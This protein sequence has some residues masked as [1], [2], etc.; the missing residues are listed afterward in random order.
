MGGHTKSFHQ[1]V[2]DNKVAMV[3]RLLAKKPDLVNRGDMRNIHP[4]FFAKSLDMLK[5]L[6][7]HKADVNAKD[8]DGNSVLHMAA[9]DR[10]CDW[11]QTL[12]EAKAKPNIRNTHQI[13][14]LLLAIYDAP[15]VRLLLNAQANPTVTT[16][17]KKNT[18]LHLATYNKR[19]DI[20]EM[21][22]S[23]QKPEQVD[24]ADINGTTALMYAAGR[25][26][27]Q[28]V[29]LLLDNEADPNGRAKSGATALFY[30]SN[31][32]SGLDVFQTLLEGK[33]NINLQDKDGETVLMNAIRSEHARDPA[34]IHGGTCMNPT[35]IFLWEQGADAS[36]RD[37]NGLPALY[38]KDSNGDVVLVEPKT[39]EGEVDQ[40]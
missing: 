32:S 20:M 15:S 23:V 21:L 22:L 40:G 19:F 27:P 24:M 9:R 38:F 30:A 39:R 10:G 34:A 29:R 35:A 12:L 25:D 37:N 16:W 2:V 3:R 31:F 11:V 1:A 18:P 28:G 4:V 5:L 8:A 26:F 7:Q 14:P 33:A 17:D 6:V 36:V 13:T